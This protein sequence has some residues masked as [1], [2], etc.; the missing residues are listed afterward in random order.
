VRINPDHHCRHRITPP[1]L[2]DKD[3]GGHVQHHDFCGAHASSGPRHGETWQAGTSFVSQPGRRQAVREPGQPGPLNETSRLT[4]IPARPAPS[5]KS[6]SGG[7]ACVI[8]VWVRHLASLLIGIDL[9]SVTTSAR[10]FSASSS[11]TRR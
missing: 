2:A 11:L 3:R 4:F 10:N 7:S 5:T 9:N 1:L 8:S 6:Q